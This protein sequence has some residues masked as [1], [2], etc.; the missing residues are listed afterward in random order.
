[1]LDRC[2]Q[3]FGDKPS[4]IG[5]EATSSVRPF[6]R[7]SSSLGQGRAGACPAHRPSASRTAST[8]ARS[9]AGS[10][11]PGSASTPLETSTPQGRS[12]L[13]ASATLVELRPPETITG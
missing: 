11:F 3:G 6:E 2:G 1:F 9:L 8:K 12:R 10:F 5:S 7:L 4:T 13:I